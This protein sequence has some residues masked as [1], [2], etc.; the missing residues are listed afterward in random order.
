MEKYNTVSKG[1][2]A[3]F[4]TELGQSVPRQ[5]SECPRRAERFC[6]RLLKGA[7][8]VPV[9]RL[10]LAGVSPPRSEGGT[11]ARSEAQG[12]AGCAR[13]RRPAAPEQGLSAPRRSGRP[14]ERLC[15]NSSALSHS[16]GRPPPEGC[17]ARW[18]RSS[19]PVRRGLPAGELGLL[20][21][22]SCRPWPT[23][24]LALWSEEGLRK[25]R[26]G[27][28][29]GG[30]GGGRGSGPV[31]VFSG[32]PQHQDEARGSPGPRRSGL[33][34]PG[35][36]PCGP[37]GQPEGLAACERSHRGSSLAPSLIWL[38]AHRRRRLAAPRD[39]PEGFILHDCSPQPSL[40]DCDLTYGRAD[41]SGL[42]SE[43]APFKDTEAYTTT[44][45][46][47]AKGHTA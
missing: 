22:Q 38:E 11:G 1:K 43:G 18:R 14:P 6:L 29:G 33:G 32:P 44:Q 39:I 8:E 10:E 4:Y 12:K 7:G 36:P 21:P 9:A 25:G 17:R 26:R 31:R 16:P 40:L 30:G 13:Q 5:R 20:A 24:G 42:C 23:A 15:P 28:K 41:P 2:Y 27:R 45:L 46:V 34:N 19:G 37:I 35:S 3:E 47:I